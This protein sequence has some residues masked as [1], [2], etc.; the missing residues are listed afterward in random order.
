MKISTRITVLSL[1]PQTRYHDEKQTPGWTGGGNGGPDGV[2]HGDT[3]GNNVSGPTQSGHCD[4][5][6][7]VSCGEYLWGELLPFSELWVVLHSLTE[8][9]HRQT[10]GMARC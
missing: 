3:I 6:H 2:C 9:L 8:Q 4:C 7:G 10:T 5:G 1:A